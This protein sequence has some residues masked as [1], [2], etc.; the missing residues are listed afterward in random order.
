MI[1][2]S[3]KHLKTKDKFQIRSLKNEL[4]SQVAKG[5]WKICIYYTNV[6]ASQIPAIMDKIHKSEQKS[7][8]ICHVA[9]NK[10]TDFV[11]KLAA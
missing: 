9:N 5:N 11:W 7:K 3:T 10:L 1:L 6:V 8:N 2:L 4:N